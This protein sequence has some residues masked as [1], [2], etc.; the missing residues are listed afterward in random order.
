LSWAG[1][2][3]IHWLAATR[4]LAW[5]RPGAGAFGNATVLIYLAVTDG[6]QRTVV[7]AR[8][9]RMAIPSQSEITALA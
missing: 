3:T 5:S 8:S 7:I 9:Q 4:P 6:V 1:Q 2:E